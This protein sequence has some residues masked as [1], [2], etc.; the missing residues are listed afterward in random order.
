[1][2]NEETKWKC[3]RGDNS[4]IHVRYMYLFKVAVYTNT[5]KFDEI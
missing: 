3:E 4:H 2:N 1:M 5:I